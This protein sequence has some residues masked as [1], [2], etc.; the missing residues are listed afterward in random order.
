M[1]I[2]IVWR[3]PIMLRETKHSYDY[4]CSSDDLDGCGVYFFARKFG[5]TVTP[6]YV[7]QTT[8]QTIR[9]RLKQHLNTVDFVSRLKEAINGSIIFVYGILK[10]VRGM[11]I[12]KALVVAE[13]ALIQ[14]ALV[15]NEEMFNKRGAREPVHTVTLFGNKIAKKAINR[16]VLTVKKTKS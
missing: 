12:S 7:G 1:D 10:P 3:K 6:L 14:E 5:E 9:A 11:Q 8:Q 4:E 16:R 15:E 13:R 2:D